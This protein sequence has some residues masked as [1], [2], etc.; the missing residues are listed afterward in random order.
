MYAMSGIVHD[1]AAVASQSI[2]Q[3]NKKEKRNY[4]EPIDLNYQT[5]AGQS[6]FQF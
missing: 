1:T 3:L 4:K 2:C 5:F 6:P